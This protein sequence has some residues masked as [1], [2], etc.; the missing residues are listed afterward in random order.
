MSV[1]TGGVGIGADRYSAFVQVTL[2]HRVFLGLTRKDVQVLKGKSCPFLY[3]L[4][5]VFRPASYTCLLYGNDRIY[6][7]RNRAFSKY[8]TEIRSCE[9]KALVVFVECVKY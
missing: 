3:E 7:R 6:V 8:Q 1:T 9:R 4:K 2:Y 5:L